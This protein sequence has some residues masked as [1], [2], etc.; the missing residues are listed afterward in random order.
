MLLEKYC[1]HYEAVLSPAR[2]IIHLN[3]IAFKITLIYFVYM[4]VWMYEYIRI[5]SMCT[6]V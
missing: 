6:R 2:V 1:D 3:S 5:M 4:Y